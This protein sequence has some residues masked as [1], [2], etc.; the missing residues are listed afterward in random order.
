[1][2]ITSL[3]TFGVLPKV[4]SL[5]LFWTGN[6]ANPAVAGSGTWA[7]P[8]ASPV[9]TPSPTWSSTPGTSRTPANWADGS[10]AHFLG[11]V[12]GTVTL[13]SNITAAK[14]NFDLN[15]VAGASTGAFTIATSG[16]TLTVKGAIMNSSGKAQMITNNGAIFNQTPEGNT[17]AGRGRTEFLSAS[18]TGSITITN[19]SGSTNQSAPPVLQGGLTEF[20]GTSTAGSAKIINNAG[21]GFFVLGGTTR[22]FDSSDGGTASVTTNGNGT[23]DISG[24]TTTGM[25]IGSIEGSGNYFLGSKTL[26]VGGNNLSTTVSGVIQDGGLSGGTG[27]S[28]TKVGTGTLTLTGANT[29][30]GGT[31]FNG[32]ILAVISDGNLGTGPLS[33]DGGT[34]EALGGTSLVSSKPITLNPGGGTFLAD[35]STASTLSGAIIGTGAW[36]KAGLGTLTLSGTN[37]YTGTT[38]VNAGVLRAGSTGGFSASSAFTV[39]TGAVL[40][41]NGFDN[42][43]GSL[44]GSGTVSNNG[45]IGSDSFPMPA[46]ATLSVGANNTSTTFSGTLQDGVFSTFV[47]TLALNKVG[48]GTLILTGTNTYTGPTTVN[49][50]SL[51]VDGSIASVQTLV[52]T[53]GLLGGRGVLGGNLVNSGIVSPGDS[54]GTLHVSSNY[55]QSANGTLRIEIAG[56]A[57]GQFDLLAVGKHASL[58]GTLQLIPLGG[59]KLQVGDKVTFLTA[60]GGVS[61]TFSAIQNEFATIVKTQIIILPTAVVLEGT[62]GSFV[63]AACNPNSVAVAQALDNAVGDPRAAGLISFLNNEPFNKLCSDFTLIAPEALASVYNTAVSLAN[64]QTAN[65]E[66]RMDDIRVGSTGFSSAGFTMNGITPSFSGGLGGPTGAEGKAGPSVLAPIPENRWGVFATGLGEFTHVDSTDAARGFDLQTGGFTLGVDYRVCPNFAVG[67]LAGYAHTNADL[68]NNGNL[69]VNSGTFGLYA[70][71]FSG[72]FY[73]DTAVTGGP[74]EYNSHRTALL[75]TASGS[76]D[77]GDLN[78]LVDGGYDWKKGG[79]SIGP[80]AS[81]QYTY[82][83]FNGFTETGSLAPLKFND[84]HVDSIRTAFGGKASYDWKVGHV[85]VRPELRA[86]WQHEYG[87]SAYSIVASFADGAGTSFTVSSPRIGRDSLLLGA[88]VAVLWSDRIST[89]IYY[90][91]ELGRTNYDSHNVSAGVRVTF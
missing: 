47:S 9:P 86:A 74:S 72:G 54:P 80:T 89:Y 32:G 28:L 18:I 78:V 85:L 77:G 61:G 31:N 87:N 10:V 29:Y 19:D 6:A 76:T 43:V 40:D 15:P 25:G 39:N 4:W 36:T 81:F 17:S 66:R 34:L 5:D 70:T 30:T 71:A 45:F 62:Q 56:T 51:I 20:R 90:D 35:A 53:S 59:F 3:L 60:S 57:Q 55:T 75:G 27:G 41:L 52:N 16:N 8:Q 65:L 21:A 46:D 64:V 73:L 49:G 1:V 2:F 11:S 58:G 82:V 83:S 22:F 50:G 13:G 69:D 91:G 14:I 67:L 7:L 38:T 42:K 48:T 24:L 88:G 23:F 68:A 12:G 79:L 37:T 84:Q 63:P 33:F 44:S 26:S